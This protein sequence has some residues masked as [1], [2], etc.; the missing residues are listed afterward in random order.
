MKKEINV[1][2]CDQI[3]ADGI[4]MLQQ[5]GF[6]VNLN[7]EI[8]SEEL[9]KIVPNYNVLIIRSRTKVTS[10]IINEG[11]NLKVVARA[12]VGLDNVDLEAAKRNGIVVFNSPEASSKAV[13]E[14]TLGL[15]LSLARNI[16]FADNSVKEGKWIK[17]QLE[18]WQL[19]DKTI[20][21]IGLGN[22]GE[23]VARLAKSF[24]MKILITKRTPPNPQLLAEL[25]GEYVSLEK[26]LRGSDIVSIH[27]P[28]TSETN[29]MIGEEEIQLMKD[30]AY[31]INTSRGQ[32]VDEKALLKALKS[33]KLTGVALDVFSVEPPKD[34]ELMKMPNVVCTPHIG[35]Q[36][37]EAQG[38]AAVIIA[39]KIINHFKNIT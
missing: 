33:K 14:L 31:L 17:N 9:K 39:E 16:P 30:N 5:A 1:L 22:I 3:H 35:G 37:V 8:T 36:T 7:T 15:I 20:G 24:G 29:L 12:G 2:V 34:L 11:K 6:N 38:K 28:F 18:G 25:A 4:K 19:E 13:A 27:V 23:C 26:L 21:L 10:D 32:I